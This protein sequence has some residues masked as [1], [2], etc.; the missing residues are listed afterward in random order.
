[1]KRIR[2]LAF[3]AIWLVT[4]WNILCEII[5]ETAGRHI[6]KIWLKDKKSLDIAE[7]YL[8]H[9]FI[10]IFLCQFKYISV[11]VLQTTKKVAIS[12]VQSIFTLLVSLP[13]FSI[14]LYFTSKHDPGR[15]LYSFSLYDALSFI[16]C[17]IIA[18]F[19]SRF[20]FLKDPNSMKDL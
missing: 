3:H 20:L 13:L 8:R 7:H 1:M 4:I 11:K 5:L 12:V 18:F 14:I 16:I 15:L 2:N 10:C 6:A 17:I 9:S 19:T